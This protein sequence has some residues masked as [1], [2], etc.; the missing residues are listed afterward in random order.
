MKVKD[1]F[2]Y[3][4]QNENNVRAFNCVKNVIGYANQIG[5]KNTEREYIHILKIMIELDIED[6][7]L[8]EY[9]IK[10]AKNTFHIMKS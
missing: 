8:S 4:V 2:E 3:E 7:E 1:L 5:F 6:I 10:K 9:V